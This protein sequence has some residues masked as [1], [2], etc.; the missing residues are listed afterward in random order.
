ML[1]KARSITFIIR[2]IELSKNPILG[3]MKQRSPSK[4]LKDK[5][6]NNKKN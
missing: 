6:I 5:K 1:P 2:K 3:L 4:F